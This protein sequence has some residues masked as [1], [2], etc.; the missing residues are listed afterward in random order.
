MDERKLLIRIARGEVTNVG[1]ADICKLAEGLGFELRRVSGSHHVS[2]IPISKSSS[3]S[4][5][6]MGRPSLTRCAGS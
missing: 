3:I 2:S 1:F 5:L 4:S 6:S